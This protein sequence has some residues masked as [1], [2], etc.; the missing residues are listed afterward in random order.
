MQ[1]TLIRYG[2]RNENLAFL[3]SSARYGSCT[4]W[5][6]NT[7]FQSMQKKIPH[8]PCPG[9]CW[10][11]RGAPGSPLRLTAGAGARCSRLG[12]GPSA[13]WSIMLIPY[14]RRQSSMP[15]VP[16]SYPLPIPGTA[17]RALTGTR[18]S[19][20]FSPASLDSGTAA[21]AWFW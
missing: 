9:H 3:S 1:G 8:S 15:H 17:C 7:H 11:D 13:G 12:A 6:Q 10:P 5:Q 21:V 2:P 19:C 16:R 20:S 18:R 14:G 4:H